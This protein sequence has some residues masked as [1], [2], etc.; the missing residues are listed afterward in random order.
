VLVREFYTQAK[1]QFEGCDEAAIFSLLSDAVRLLVNKG[2][3]DA[4]LG[5]MEICACNGCL[6]L[7]RDVGTVL[8][9]DVCGH[10][11]LI[12]DQWFKYHINGPGNYPGCGVITEMGQVCTYK[13][14]SAPCYLVAEVTSAAE[15]NKKLRVYATDENGKKI[16]T[17]GPDGKL[18]EGFLVPTIFGFSQ[19]NPSVPAITS[20]YRITKEVTKDYVR[21]IAVNSSDGLSQT[22][23]GYYEPDETTPSYRRIKVPNKTNVLIKYKKASLQIR[24]QGD[25]IN[26]D[27]YEALRLACRAVKFR[28]D[29]KIEQA[30]GFEEEAARILSE[31]TASKL[32][33]GPRVPQIINQVFGDENNGLYYSDY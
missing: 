2:I 27:N 1:R 21:L 26:I 15:N 5:E 6:T 19:R 30:R 3:T 23:I 28:G 29:D 8:G 32:P 33:A 4:S 22:Q 24:N 25:W 12:Q 17:P 7:P 31:E 18:Y 14:P 13:E 9:I 11:T 10:P 20:I 16:F